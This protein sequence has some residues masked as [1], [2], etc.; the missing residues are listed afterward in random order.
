MNNLFTT[1]YSLKEQKLNH[2]KYSE[3]ELN[4]RNFSQATEHYVHMYAKFKDQGFS[5][6]NFLWGNKAQNGIWLS[7]LPRSTHKDYINL[8]C[9]FLSHNLFSMNFSRLYEFLKLF[10]L[11]KKFKKGRNSA[12]PE[13]T[14]GGEGAA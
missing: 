10:N 9:I 7:L 8:F 11:E 6:R 1:I 12:G 3:L 2:N 5:Y 14:Q 4:M 13:S